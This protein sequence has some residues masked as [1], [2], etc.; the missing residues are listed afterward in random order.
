MNFKY[1]LLAGAM[2]FAFAAA[3]LVLHAEEED[4]DALA[5]TVG[6][7]VG[8][9]LGFE[10]PSADEVRQI[11]DARTTQAVSERVG[12][13][14][15]QAFEYY[16][17]DQTQEAIQVLRDT[18][19]RNDFDRA[20]LARFI[21]NLLASEDELEEATAQLDRAVTLDRLSFGDHGAAI[22]LLADL[23]LQ[24]E[25][26]EEALQGY[27]NWIQFTGELDHEVFMR[28]ANAHLEL[29]NYDRVIPFARK[30]VAHQ[31]TPNRNPYVLQVAA[32]YET[33]QIAN[34]IEVLEEGLEVL[35]GEERW[36]GQLGMFYLLEEDVERALA[37][38]EIAYLAGYLTRE[39]DF[40]ALV[41][42]YSNIGIPYRAG[43]VMDEHIESGQIE[44]T[45]RNYSI[46]ARSYHAAREF[47]DAANLYTK[48]IES[49]DDD[50]QRRD[51]YRRQGDALLLI[52]RYSDAAEAFSNSVQ[53][54]DPDDDTSGRVYM[55]LAEAH[56]YAEQYSEAL[57]AAENAARYDAQRRNAESWAGYIRTTA[58]RRGVEL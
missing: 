42:M 47:A 56:F 16:E 21:G 14:I 35:P 41:Q 49:S 4:P 24:Q 19:A 50:D 31:E 32:F 2:A 17:E 22:R 55:S 10:I 5:E 9:D 8:I 51:F 38:M 54:T 53:L 40:R 37:T 39:N 29:Q 13:S 44:G 20:Y 23:N 52:N 48:A 7:T 15:M 43:K 3:P 33:Q 11:R 30:S 34:A 1:T 26:Y 45:P 28:M 46:A 36:W 58:E 57:T 18:T 6:D 12:R 27:Q 25:N